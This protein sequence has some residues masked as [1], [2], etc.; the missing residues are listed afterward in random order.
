MAATDIQ[1]KPCSKCNKG[2]GVFTCDGCEQ[3]FCRKHSDGHRQELGVQMD[4]IGQEYDLLQ[5]ELNK[6]AEEHSLLTRIDRW[7]QESVDKIHQVAKQARIDL[8]QL[9][10][11]NK[12]DL[13]TSMTQITHELQSSRESEDYT[14]LDLNGWIDQ[15]KKF[16]SE[17][18][19]PLT[20]NII[21]D[22]GDKRSVIRLIRISNQ[23]DSNQLFSPPDQNI[24][25][26]SKSISERFEQ[27]DKTFILSEDGLVA[28]CLK[29]D[30]RTSSIRGNRCYSTGIHH[31]SFRI[32]QKK[33]KYLFLGVTT[34]HQKTFALTSTTPKAN[35]WWELEL[36]I[37]N[38]RLHEKSSARSIRTGD[39]VTLTLNCDHRQIQFEHHR[40]KQIAQMPIDLK[41]CPFPW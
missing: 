15:L 10:D 2:G 1:K 22:D 21:N 7:E 31:I 26:L 25:N 41:K 18:E 28:K 30:L 13:K 4:N 40:T 37:V 6:K 8:R 35:G 5:R 29:S 17:L 39:E 9:I 23:Q 12:N 11:Q 32:E 16:R 36:S 27:I 19:K 14:E 24:R 20:P 33:S 3:S 34:L 38:G